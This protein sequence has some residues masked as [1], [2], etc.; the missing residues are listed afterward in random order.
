M[1]KEEK[2]DERKGKKVGPPNIMLFKKMF[3]LNN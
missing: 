3:N 2:K 1:K